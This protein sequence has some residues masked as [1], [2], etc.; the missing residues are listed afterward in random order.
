MDKELKALFEI[1]FNSTYSIK[2]FMINTVCNKEVRKWPTATIRNST[3]II[4]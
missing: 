3:Y 4:K 1:I 2:S